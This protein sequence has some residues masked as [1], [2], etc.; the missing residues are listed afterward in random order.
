MQ[1]A[2]EMENKVIVK[3]IMSFPDGRLDVQNASQ[4]LGLSTKTLAMMR[5][6]G[7]GPVFV[8]RGKIFYYR[9]NLDAWMRA[10]E[11]TSTIKKKDNETDSNREIKRHE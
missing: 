1:D 8:K 3:Q 11:Q 4:Y 6:S 5:C 2:N 10:G 7:T 9:D